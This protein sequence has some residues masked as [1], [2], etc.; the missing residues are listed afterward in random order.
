MPGNCLKF[1]H[2]R[3]AGQLD[4]L[5]RTSWFSGRPPPAPLNGEQWR[6][7]FTNTHHTHACT[8]ICTCTHTCMHACTHLRA[9]TCTH[10]YAHT[11]TCTHTCTYVCTHVQT[12]MHLCTYAHTH[13][14]TY[15]CAHTHK[16]IPPIHRK[17]KKGKKERKCAS[18]I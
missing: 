18:T 15:V 10:V 3:H 9:H 16:H 8:H 7:M 11:V 13:A 14:F 1:Q 2:Q 17:E 5:E 4:W 12:H 6:L